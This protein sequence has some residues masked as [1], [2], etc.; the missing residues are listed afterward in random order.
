MKELPS[1]D[2][3]DDSIDSVSLQMPIAAEVTLENANKTL[4]KED[5]SIANGMLRAIGIMWKDV[6]NIY[7][8]RSIVTS[9]I[10]AT[11]HRR[12]ILKKQYGFISEDKPKSVYDPLD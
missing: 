1:P 2:A 6:E 5:L 8:L 7:D 4:D 9:T 3:P 12:A 10:D 11:K